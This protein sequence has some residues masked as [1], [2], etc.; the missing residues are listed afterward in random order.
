MTPSLFFRVKRDPDIIGIDVLFMMGA[1]KEK[2]FS[3]RVHTTVELNEMA[4]EGKR[5][6]FGKIQSVRSPDSAI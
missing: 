1:D 4:V 5:K 3:L 6:S 2:K